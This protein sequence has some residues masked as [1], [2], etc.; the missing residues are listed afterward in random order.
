MRICE[1]SAD[2]I[3]LLFSEN[4]KHITGCECRKGMT[5]PIWKN[6]QNHQLILE[7]SVRSIYYAKELFRLIEDHEEF[8]YTDNKILSRI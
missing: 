1:I 4:L 8:V 6:V 5:V 7:E 3:I 2:M